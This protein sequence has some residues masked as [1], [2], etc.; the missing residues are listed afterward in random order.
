[1]LN[2]Q[3]NSEAILWVTGKFIRLFEGPYFV[4]RIIPLTKFELKDDRGKIKGEFNLKSLKVYHE[5]TDQ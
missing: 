4:S 5:A 1:L 2:I 3:P